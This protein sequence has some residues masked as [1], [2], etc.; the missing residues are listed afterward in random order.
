MLPPTPGIGTNAATA[1]PPIPNDSAQATNTLI[2][3]ARGPNG[4]IDVAKLGQSVNALRATNPQLADSIYARLES[5][6]TPSQQGELLR[7]QTSSTP[8][9]DGPSAGSLALDVTQIGLDI[10]GIFDP[11]PISDGSNAV[12][13]LF[14]GDFSGAGIS[15]LGFIPV[16]GDAA[17]LGKLGKWGETLAK[18]IDFAKVNSAFAKAIAPALEKIAD[19]IRAAPLDK[20]PD[21]A[22]R[23]LE[24][25]AGSIEKHLAQ[26]ERIADAARTSGIPESTVRD[27]VNTPNGSRPAPS[28]YMSDTQIA[29]HLKPFQ[30]SGAVRFTSRA[31]INSYGTLGPANG[32]F[33]IPRSEL[34]RVVTETGGDLAQIEQKLGLEAGTLSNGD[35]VIAF[36]KPENLNNLRMPS[37]NEM[38]ANTYWVP[39]G[40]TSGGVPEA[41]V[42]VPAGTR[43]TEIT[44]AP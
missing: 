3:Q 16:L 12:I 19:A 36:I 39:G 7:T 35:T 9:E 10:A 33:T 28:T 26:G 1:S 8:R 15:A 32:T 27:I 5:Q 43:Y 34:D 21:G 23:Q 25:I 6:L 30:E 4:Q 17:K 41:T 31:D 38:G 11:T 40:N 14:R 42:D 24:G 37:G 18:A 29:A 2:A 44:L 22:R 13:S 20:L